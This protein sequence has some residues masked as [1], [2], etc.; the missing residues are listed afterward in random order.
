MK[1]DF[2]DGRRNGNILLIGGIAESHEHE[3][4]YSL[5]TPIIKRMRARCETFLSDLKNARLD[6]G[7][8]LA[9]GLRP[10]RRRNVRVERE[11]RGHGRVAS[12]IVHSY[13]HGG[14]G[15]SLSFGCAGDVAVLVE[16]ALLDLPARPVTGEAEEHMFEGYSAVKIP[17]E[18]LGVIVKPRL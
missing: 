13:G 16:K 12:L 9:Q 17:N 4:E 18:G 1:G 7:Y 3:L 10:F 8:P 5:E 14:A 6:P 15:W 2:R 11:Q